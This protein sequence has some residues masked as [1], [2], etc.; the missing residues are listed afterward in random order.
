[1]NISNIKIHTARNNSRYATYV[2]EGKGKGC[3][4]IPKSCV[5]VSDVAT[6]LS[7]AEP[8]H[9]EVEKT[10]NRQGGVWYLFT[11]KDGWVEDSRRDYDSITRHS[12]ARFTER[13]TIMP[14][15]TGY[16]QVIDRGYEEYYYYNG[17]GAVEITEEE[18]GAA[19]MTRNAA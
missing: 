2:I 16:F 1:M 18:M 17:V 7:P 11:G 13:H 3:S 10:G 6:W 14:T 19:L 9:V 8:W 4:F 12:R 15:E 5:S